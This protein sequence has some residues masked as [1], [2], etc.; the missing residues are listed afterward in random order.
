[1]DSHTVPIGVLRAIEA[2]ANAVDELAD[3]SEDQD[4]GES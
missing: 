2:L 4:G 1:M 3:V